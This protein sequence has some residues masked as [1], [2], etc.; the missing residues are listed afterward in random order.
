VIF[1]QPMDTAAVLVIRAAGQCGT[2][3]VAVSVC[4]GQQ[5]KSPTLTTNQ[6][7]SARYLDRPEY[8]ASDYA[9]IRSRPLHCGTIYRLLDR[10]GGARHRELPPVLNQPV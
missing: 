10:T 9:G 8:N 2:K 7:H 6:H 3:L 5:V 4:P 1:D